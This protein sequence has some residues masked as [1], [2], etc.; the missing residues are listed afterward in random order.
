[1]K[2]ITEFLYACIAE[3]ASWAEYWVKN[4]SPSHDTV[5]SGEQMLAE[6]EAKRRIIERHPVSRNYIA[7]GG[8]FDAEPH[9]IEGTWDIPVELFILAQPY[10]DRSGFDEAWRIR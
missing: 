10:S 4:Y 5:I 8:V 7:E 6:C 1:M 9:Y 2:N 3:D